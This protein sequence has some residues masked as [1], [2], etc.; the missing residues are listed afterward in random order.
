MERVSLEKQMSQGCTDFY[1]KFVKILDVN[2][3]F[4]G[5]YIS[6]DRT[7]LF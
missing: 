5:Q 4:K 7:T 2:V 6:M 3:V 1:I